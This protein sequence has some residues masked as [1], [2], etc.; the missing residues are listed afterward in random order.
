MNDENQSAHPVSPKSS[1]AQTLEG[2]A[3]NAAEDW[4]SERGRA[5]YALQKIILAAIK[6][7][8]ELKEEEQTQLREFIRRTET[9]WQNCNTCREAFEELGKPEADVNAGDPSKQKEV[10]YDFAPWKP[11]FSYEPEG[12]MICDIDEKLILDIRGWGFLTGRG[13]MRSGTSLGLAETE[14][15]AIQDAL[16]WHVT[17]LLNDSSVGRASPHLPAPISPTP[18]PSSTPQAAGRG[19]G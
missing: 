12:S 4:F 2:I 1:A 3:R 10:P 6:A 17:K 9:H 15:A 16:G 19:E 7:G 5:L 8:V 18:S 13:G 11:P 14:A